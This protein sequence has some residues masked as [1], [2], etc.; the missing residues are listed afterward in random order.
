MSK[1]RLRDHLQNLALILL[2]LSALFLLT[3]L[4]MLQNIRWS[5]RTFFAPDQSAGGGEEDALPAG[6]F[7]SVNLMVTGDSEY[8]RSGLLCVSADDAVL[9][10]VLPLFREALGSAGPAEPAAES[11]FR[12]ALAGPGF[13]LELGGAVLPLE[14]VAAWLEEEPP[15]FSIEL[16]AMVLTVGEETSLY[17]RDGDGGIFRCATAL[18]GSAVLP[19]CEDFPPNGAAFAYESAYTS[20]MPYTILASAPAPLPDL[21]SELPAGYSAYNLLTALDFNAHTLSR[22]KESD[23]TEVVEESPRTLR[24]SPDGAVRF[25]SREGSGSPL[26][27]ASGEGL[28]E[29]L[30]AA[31]RLASALTDGVGASPVYLQSVEERGEGEYVFRFRYQSEGVPV[32]FPDEGDAL[33]VEFQKGLIVGFDYRC[34][35]YRAAEEEPEAMLPA[36]LAQAIAASY[37]QSGLFVG[38]EDDGSG[39]LSARWLR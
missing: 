14:A 35:V 15:D 16:C 39:Q 9:Q 30:A 1:K 7:S 21:F 31:W 23:G 11:A 2:T 37:P 24:I 18:P 20:L 13:Y 5:Q 25:L 33:T 32:F 22:Y 17:L 4:P 8:G 12:D 26:Y 29:A 38:Y 3:R 6:M 19:V 10:A 27:R 36:A 34:R 28:R